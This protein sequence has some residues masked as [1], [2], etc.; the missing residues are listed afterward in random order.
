MWT[1]EEEF[2]GRGGSKCKGPVVG[3]NLA[4]LKTV[5]KDESNWE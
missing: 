1:W 4:C 2:P 5:K 3:Q